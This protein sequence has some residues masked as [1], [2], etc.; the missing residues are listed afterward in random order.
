M[1]R[2][3]RQGR[4]R[5][6]FAFWIRLLI[7]GLCGW[8]CT[9]VEQP[10]VR[11]EPSKARPDQEIW[12]WTAELTQGG[13]KRAVVKAGHFQKYDRSPKTELDEGVTV[14]FYGSYGQK[15]VSRLT[16]QRAEIDDKTNDM[17]VFDRVVLI[18]Q[19]STRLETDSLSWHRESE[20]ITG[21]GRVTI[22]R[23]DGVETGVGFEA[24]SDL[25]RWTM[26]QVITRLGGAD[27]L[28]L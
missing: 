22:R 28:G 26:H 25:K 13:R 15:Q 9:Q 18:A 7:L 23:P 16:A 4:P 10:P 19:D 20:K 2:A 5:P 6:P 1:N 21:E 12:G 27:S 14:L 3:G 17:M 8:G 24:S 11:P